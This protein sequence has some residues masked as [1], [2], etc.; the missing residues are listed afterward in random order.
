MIYAPSIPL[1]FDNSYGYQNV[2]D[3]NELV[4]FHLTNLIMTNPG[5]RIA[6]PGYG[7]GM[8]QF[9][10]ENLT[11]GLLLR[12][13][14]K[15]LSQ[16]RDY[17]DYL[18]INNVDASDNGDYSISVKI[19]YTVGSINLSDALEV[20]IDLNSGDLMSETAGVNY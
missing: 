2:S 19:Q 6:Q 14:T 13:E 5:E 12:I 11:T 20:D 8:R 4:K 18:T 1:S 9:L 15:I 16:V 3:V 7:V 10:F 17:L